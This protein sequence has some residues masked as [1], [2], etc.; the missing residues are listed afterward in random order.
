[1]SAR[2]SSVRTPVSSDKTMY[3]CRLVFSAAASNASACVKV[4]D[5]DGRPVRPWG[6]SH[7]RTTLRSTLSLACARV[8][9]RFR[10]CPL[11]ARSAGQHRELT[12]TPGQP[13]TSVHLHTGRLTR[14]ANRPSK[15]RVVQVADW[16]SACG[17]WIARQRREGAPLPG[18]P[19]TGA[20]LADAHP[21]EEAGTEV[22]LS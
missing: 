3:A 2:S 22:R 19:F 6:I 5:F 20:E 10:T 12:V 9:A 21:G 16:A 14:C 13:D 4:S 15:Q 18:C 1:M 7:S 17:M 11:R 8:I